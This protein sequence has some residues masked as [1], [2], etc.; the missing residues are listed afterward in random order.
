MPTFATPQPITAVVE[1]VSGS[2]QMTAADRDDTVVQVRPRDPNRAS[3]VRAAEKT[4]VEFRN[5]TL[6]VAASTRLISLGGAVNVDIELPSRSRLDVSSVSARLQAD[7]AFGDCRYAAA[8]GAATIEA[9]TGNLKSDS[10]S[11]GISVDV[12]TGD[13]AVSTASGD[14]TIGQLT[15]EARFRASSGSLSVRRLRGAVHAQTASGDV[16]VA[17]AVNGEVSVQT[18]SGEV[19]VGIEEGTAARLELRTHSGTVRNDLQPT[20]GPGQAEE[21]LAVKVLTASGNITARRATV[22]AV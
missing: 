5:G 7:G 9:I 8:S 22:A 2:V 21:T 15:G 16:T 12:L 19:E 1:I 6:T 20:D 18:G 4:R 11:G 10:T 13:A 17:A 14:V 3:D